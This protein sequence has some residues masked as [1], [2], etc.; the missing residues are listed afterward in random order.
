MG[1]GLGSSA[2]GSSTGTGGSA[3]GSPATTTGGHHDPA[4]PSES[5]DDDTVTSATDTIG[6]D[7]YGV[8]SAH[9]VSSIRTNQPFASF[10]SFSSSLNVDTSTPALP[11]LEA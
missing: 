10:G 5:L 9:D 2:T 1:G 6:D 3:R 7:A 4:D 11:E 8:Y